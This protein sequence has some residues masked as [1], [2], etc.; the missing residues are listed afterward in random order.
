VV[1][2]GLTVGESVILSPYEIEPKL[3]LPDKFTAG[4]QGTGKDS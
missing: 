2:S 1:V 4:S 3:D